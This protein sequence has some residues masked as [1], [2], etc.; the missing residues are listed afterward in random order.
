MPI[1]DNAFPNG[2]LPSIQTEAIKET[3]EAFGGEYSIVIQLVELF[4]EDASKQLR[5]LKDAAYQ[6]D[7]NKVEQVAHMVKSTSASIGALTLAEHCSEVEIRNRQGQLTTAE[8]Q[9]FAQLLEEEFRQVNEALRYHIE[10]G[11]LNL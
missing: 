8:S 2:P 11:L 5:Y 10:T 1:P 4:L 9:R 6:G 3:I 7:L